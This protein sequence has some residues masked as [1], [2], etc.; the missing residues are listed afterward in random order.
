MTSEQKQLKLLSLIHYNNMY[1]IKE[2]ENMALKA[3]IKSSAK[4][5]IDFLVIEN[6]IK[7][8]K[9]G[10]SNIYW[11]KPENYKLILK[12]LNKE[13]ELIKYN[14]QI[15][16]KDIN[17]IK[18]LLNNKNNIEKMTELIKIKEEL[19]NKENQ[20]NQFVKESD[21]K[22]VES[23]V[24]LLNNKLNLITDNIFSIISFLQNK[25]Q[26]RSEI[27]KAFCIPEDFDYF[28]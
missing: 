24:E 23:K 3:D 28:I 20:L 10:I 6:L 14:K 1:H 2:L 22:E 17:N 21:Y 11:K 16:K 5:I 8:E 19:K 15:M 18:S 26:L 7:Q 12:K 4:E 27:Y 9:I 25:G 13:F